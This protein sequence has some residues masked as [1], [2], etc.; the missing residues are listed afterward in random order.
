[1]RSLTLVELAQDDLESTLL[2]LR[3][4]F[5]LGFGFA[6]ATLPACGMQLWRSLG[7]VADGCA[8][9]APLE[10]EAGHVLLLGAF[11]AA[12][13]V[14]AL[15]RVG[16]FHAMIMP[17][18]ARRTA[19]YSRGRHVARIRAVSE[20]RAWTATLVLGCA[21]Y[22]LPL[23]GF[24]AEVA[25]LGAPLEAPRGRGECERERELQ[26]GW[27]VGG[28]GLWAWVLSVVGLRV[29]LTFLWGMHVT[30]SRFSHLVAMQGASQASID[31]L[32]RVRPGEGSSATA[33]TEACPV[34]LS[35]MD[36]A[37]E[38]L[39]ELPCDSRHRFHAACIT[40]W[41]RRRKVCPLCMLDVDSARTQQRKAE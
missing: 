15:L 36:D 4:F 7:A 2:L 28:S 17:G 22:V 30:S 18:A 14:H 13:V 10:A 32:R 8:A 19:N 31:G 33:A 9:P 11:V 35:A 12:L 16:S 21:V 37:A 41:L 38:E 34:C 25:S 5:L 29:F 39:I 27:Q 40:Q 6:A 1:M 24:V 23:L 20:N 3:G 26:P